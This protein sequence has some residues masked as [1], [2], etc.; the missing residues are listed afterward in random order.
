MMPE[1]DPGTYERVMLLCPHPDDETLATGGLI[2][3]AIAAGSAVKVVFVTDGENNPWPQRFLE[4]RWI[5]GDKEKARWGVRR[6]GEALAALD[7]LGIGKGD[8]A[9]LGFPDQ[10]LTSLLLSADE[11]I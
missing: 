3:R 8:A 5:I 11:R 7:S 6:R 1:L 2:Q 10:G 9:F 4:R